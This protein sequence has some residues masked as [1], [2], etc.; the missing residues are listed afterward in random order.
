MGH[1]RDINNNDN[2]IFNLF[3]NNNIKG[4]SDFELYKENDELDLFLK[5]KG[6]NN[7]K[8]FE[9]IDKSKQDELIEQFMQEGGYHK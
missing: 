6:I 1:S 5:S 3:I 7:L 2:N 9:S 8:E 4:E